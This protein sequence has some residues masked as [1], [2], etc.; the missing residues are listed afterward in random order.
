MEKVIYVE[1]KRKKKWREVDDW[2]TLLYAVLGSLLA[3]VAA[4]M[5]TAMR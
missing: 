2:L 3:L 5:G 1:K 4:F